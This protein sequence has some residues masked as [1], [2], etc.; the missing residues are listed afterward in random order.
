VNVFISHSR[1]DRVFAE[2]LGSG[3]RALG[4]NV[5][6]DES[7]LRPGESFDHAL[8]EALEASDGVVLVVPEPGS[9]QA[10][11]AFF[12]AGAARALGKPIVAVLPNAD[13]SRVGEL[14]SDVYGRAVFDGSK[15]ATEALAKSIVTAL[16]AS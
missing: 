8:R 12:E 6:S 13:P 3:I 10:N 5:V 7:R 1:A 15:V 4:A 14:P 16:E 11:S 9:A 2:R